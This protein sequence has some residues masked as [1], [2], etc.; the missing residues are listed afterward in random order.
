MRRLGPAYVAGIKELEGWTE[1]PREEG[2]RTGLGHQSSR[3]GPAEDVEPAEDVDV[4]EEFKGGNYGW[5]WPS[6]KVY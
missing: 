2:F 5:N 3:M 1:T 6:I 4:A